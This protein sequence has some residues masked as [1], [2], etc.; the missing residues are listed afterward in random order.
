VLSF[1]ITF[2]L[3]KLPFGWLLIGS[4]KKKRLHSVPSSEPKHKQ[5]AM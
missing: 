4:A 5:K 1:G 2:G 3:S